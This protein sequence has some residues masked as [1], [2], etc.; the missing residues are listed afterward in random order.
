MDTELK[1]DTTITIELKQPSFEL[2]FKTTGFMLGLEEEDLKLP[3]RYRKVM[4]KMAREIHPHLKDKFGAVEMREIFSI[5]FN[6]VLI[7]FANYDG[8]QYS[9]MN[10]FRW[11]RVHDG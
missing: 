3:H 7:G 10:V 11:E 9:V 6:D 1:L 4:F 8:E 5:Y 2:T